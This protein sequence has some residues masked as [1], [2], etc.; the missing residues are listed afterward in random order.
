MKT[1]LLTI[2][3]TGAIGFAL[4]KPENADAAQ[5]LLSVNLGVPVVVQQY[6]LPVGYYRPYRPAYWYVVPHR[7][8]YRHDYDHGY[9]G[10]HRWQH[11][12][13]RGGQVYGRAPAIQRI[14]I[15]PRLQQR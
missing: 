6:P 1:L 12:P 8:Y 13:I 14:D 15:N 10:D 11:G 9:G 3:A 2:A 7:H 4:A 5:V